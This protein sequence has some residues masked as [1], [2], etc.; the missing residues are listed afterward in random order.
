[1][2]TEKEHELA[3]QRGR[4]LYEK[5]PHAVDAVYSTAL[6]RVL[7]LLSNGLEISLRQDDYKW[8]RGASANDLSTIELNVDGLELFFPEL[9]E[10]FW[11][12]D[13][14]EHLLEVRRFLGVRVEK[15]RIEFAE[16][17][18]VKAA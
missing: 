3:E 18:K 14:L 1:V 4:E 5:V 11:I 9:D 7:I 13:L 10:G 16:R 17:D 6:R 15:E 2:I 12:P 8:M